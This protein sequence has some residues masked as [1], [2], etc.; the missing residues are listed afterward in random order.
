MLV[1]FIP[2]LRVCYLESEILRESRQALGGRSTA[3]TQCRV[4]QKCQKGLSANLI[5]G[6]IN[7]GSRSLFCCLL[8][9][10]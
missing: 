1:D 8:N 2:F 6:M 9:E 5:L 7:Y 3:A 4:I 10:N